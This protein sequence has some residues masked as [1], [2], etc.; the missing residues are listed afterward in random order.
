MGNLDGIL[1]AK[2][3]RH[4]AKEISNASLWLVQSIQGVFVAVL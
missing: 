1:S 2:G 3:S 4:Q